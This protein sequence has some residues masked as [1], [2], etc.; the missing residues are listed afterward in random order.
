VNN[1]T[2][3][4]VMTSDDYISHYLTIKSQDH[5]ANILTVLGGFY[6]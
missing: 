1:G 3:V 4:I 5:V 6:Y 2:N